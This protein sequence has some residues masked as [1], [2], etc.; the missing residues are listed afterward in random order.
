MR[1]FLGCSVNKKWRR[2][3]T[4]PIDRQI[5]KRLNQLCGALVLTVLLDSGNLDAW[6]RP[7]RAREQCGVLEHI[8]R[9]TRALA[10]RRSKE[11]KLLQLAWTR[12]TKFIWNGEFDSSN[13]LEEGGYICVY[14]RSPF[15]GKPF[16]TKVTWKNREVGVQSN[17][18]GRSL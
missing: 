12:R 8:D 3:I 18:P 6:A 1:D 4:P 10:I 16:V 15:F 2:P 9:E 5:R 7:P 17:P 14:Y 11:C 13:S